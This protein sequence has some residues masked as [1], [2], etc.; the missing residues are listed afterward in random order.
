[1]KKGPKTSFFGGVYYYYLS[2]AVSI[3]NF[4]KDFI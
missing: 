2:I 1:M 4:A 3:H